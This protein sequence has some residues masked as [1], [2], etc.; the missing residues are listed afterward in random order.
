MRHTY[1][2]KRMRGRFF[3]TLSLTMFLLLLT[4]CGTNTV[5]ST[6]AGGPGATA[7]TSAG[8]STGGTN[9]PPQ[10]SAQN[11]GTVH[12]SRL[13][14]VPT[15]QDRARDI[16][17][18]FWQE[19]Q[20]CHS[21]TM[22]YSQAGLDTATIHTF[23][24]NNQAGQCVVIDKLQSIV[25]PRAPQAAGSYTCTGLTRQADGLHFLAC[26]KEGNILVPTAGTQ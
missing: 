23:S 14:I 9:T 16:E 11:C 8:G 15:D 25:E 7:T 12:A 13:M 3:L 17:T 18:C 24:L 10:S 20:Q 5:M 2:Y 1:I 4:A 26:G 21:A 19:Y 22:G 6:G